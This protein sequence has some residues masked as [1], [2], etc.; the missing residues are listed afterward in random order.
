M[1]KGHNPASTLTLTQQSQ[2]S[3]DCV[4]KS[5]DCSQ[6][7]C[8]HT[9]NIHVGHKSVKRTTQSWLRWNQ[10]SRSLL[11]L[12]N[13]KRLQRKLQ[14]SDDYWN[15]WG[16]WWRIL[17]FFRL[18]RQMCQIPKTKGAGKSATH[19]QLK[20]LLCVSLSTR[21]V[22]SLEPWHKL[23]LRLH[24]LAVPSTYVGMGIFFE[25]R[26]ALLYL[27]AKGAPYSFKEFWG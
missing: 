6:L 24:A 9:Y 21:Y 26:T 10:L 15:P 20:T 11:L 3:I 8:K 23:K 13:N 14:N 12:V 2:Y 7:S 22:C 17:W 4:G 25:K 27:H 19:A 5:C 18:C 16:E 1:Q